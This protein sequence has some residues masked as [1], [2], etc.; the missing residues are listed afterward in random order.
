MFPLILAGY[1]ALFLTYAV[2]GWMRPPFPDAGAQAPEFTDAAGAAA[3]ILRHNLGSLGVLVLGNVVS[4]GLFGVVMFAVNGYLAGVLMRA[5][6][7][8][9]PSWLWSF[10]LPEVLAFATAGAAAAATVLGKMRV[11]TAA[12]AVGLSVVV[13]GATAVFEAMLIQLAW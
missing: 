12:R 10:V 9:A 8:H 6:A 2:L 3:G 7:P 11:P 13:L 5:A 4:V 1:L